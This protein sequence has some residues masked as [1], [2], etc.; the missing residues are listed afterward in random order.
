MIPTRWLRRSSIATAEKHDRD[1]APEGQGRESRGR[2]S[3]R[4]RC[5]PPLLDA[6]RIADEDPCGCRMVR[7]MTEKQ[8]LV[9]RSWPTPP[10][11]LPF[12]GVSGHRI[13][14]RALIGVDRAH[15]LGLWRAA[16]IH[17]TPP[18]LHRTAGEPRYL[19]DI[20][21]GFAAPAFHG[22]PQDILPQSGRKPP[23]AGSTANRKDR[24]AFQH[25]NVVRSTT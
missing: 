3:G 4:P 20:W 11:P 12:P 19:G 7:W 8:I 25:I 5:N 24:P 1:P 10:L 16:A 9:Q 6:R 21:R 23:P 15:A 18:S 13:A 14:Y 22:P 2:T 17:R